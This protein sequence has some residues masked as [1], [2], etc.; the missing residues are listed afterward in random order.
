MGEKG[1]GSMSAKLR[2][3]DIFVLGVIFAVTVIFA[4]SC[5]LVRASSRANP[6]QDFELLQLTER[7]RG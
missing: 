3:V 1:E 2:I 4:L 5:A 7:V 6:R